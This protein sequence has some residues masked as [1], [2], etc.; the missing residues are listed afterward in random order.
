M[1]NDYK[2]C[3]LMFREVYIY[4][5]STQI[6]IIMSYVKIWKQMLRT[7]RLPPGV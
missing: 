6:G 1:C 4:S 3:L 2:S 5:S 7:L